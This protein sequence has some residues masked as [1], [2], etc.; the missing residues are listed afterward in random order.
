MQLIQEPLI[1]TPLDYYSYIITVDILIIIMLNLNLPNLEFSLNEYKRYSRQLLLSSI[2]PEGQNRLSSVRIACIGAGALGS[3]IITYLAAAGVKNITV[4]DN[5][6]VD[7]S[8]LHRQ[9]IHNTS[10]I[11]DLKVA[12]VTNYIKKLNPHCNL[13]TIPDKLTRSN[14][15]KIISSHDIILD[16]SDNIATRYLLDEFCSYLG[17]PWIYGAVFQFKGQISV[18]N[19]RGSACYRDIYPANSFSDKGLSCSEGGILGVVPGLIGMLQATEAIKITLGIGDILSNYILTV[20]MLTLEFK[21]LKIRQST[22]RL[23]QRFLVESIHLTDQSAPIEI[24][25]IS[26]N[27]LENLSSIQLID[28]RSTIEY[29]IEHIPGA[30]N[31]PLSQLGHNTDFKQMLY[32]SKTLILYCSLNS[33]AELAYQ[34]LSRNNIPCKKIRNG[35]TAWKKHK[36]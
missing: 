9:P 12:S 35:L 14:S 13:K 5:D 17:K 21:K 32:N 31:Y 26:I 11:N 4:V 8:N 6:V 10:F 2:Q 24:D 28:V 33:R 1:N 7:I 29:S 22:D 36:N 34:V 27:D 19:Y 15:L 23:D 16:G 3:S 20:D 30:I 18:F 25:T